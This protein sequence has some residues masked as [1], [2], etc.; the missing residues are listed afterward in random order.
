MQILRNHFGPSVGFSV[1][2]NRVL[3][4][5]SIPMVTLIL[6]WHIII[7]KCFPAKTI[8]TLKYQSVETSMWK[9]KLIWAIFQMLQLIL[10]G[11]G[12]YHFNHGMRHIVYAYFRRVVFR[13]SH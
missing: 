11:F 1:G 13:C 4:Q 5:L 10:Q 2:K 9:M 8:S 12:E 6:T 3:F 7:L